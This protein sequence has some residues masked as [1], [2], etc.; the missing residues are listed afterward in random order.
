MF[1]EIRDLALILWGINTV[2]YF[3]TNVTTFRTYPNSIPIWEMALKAVFLQQKSP[4]FMGVF[5]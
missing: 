1:G 4:F 5:H 2:C 3:E